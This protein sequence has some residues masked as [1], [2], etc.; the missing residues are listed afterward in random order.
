MP[1]GRVEV[2]FTTQKARI[3]DYLLSDE[4]KQRNPTT[5]F[6]IDGLMRNDDSTYCGT[7]LATY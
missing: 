4:E 5:P 2:N 6:C 7:H 1:P 3:A